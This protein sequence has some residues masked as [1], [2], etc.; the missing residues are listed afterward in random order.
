MFYFDMT[1]EE[2]DK[3]DLVKLTG[4]NVG[5]S[6][7]HKNAGQHGGHTAQSRQTITSSQGTIVS[8]QNQGLTHFGSLFVTV[9]VLWDDNTSNT[10][11]YSLAR[12]VL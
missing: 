3:V 5:D 6:V 8:H 9:E 2:L 11:H 12:K 10:M 1:D 4:L 7:T